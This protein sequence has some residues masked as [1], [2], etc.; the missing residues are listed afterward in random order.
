LLHVIR[1]EKLAKITIVGVDQNVTVFVCGNLEVAQPSVCAK[2]VGLVNRCE[3]R[4]TAFVLA[5]DLRSD[6][7][8][9]RRMV[10][11]KFGAAVSRCW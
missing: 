6:V 3:K 8:V 11:A 1:S 5:V 4:L 2:S 10:V 7:A 9:D